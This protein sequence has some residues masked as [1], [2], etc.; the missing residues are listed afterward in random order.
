M[1]SPVRPSAA[2]SLS[3]RLLAAL[4]TALLTGT[5]RAGPPPTLAMSVLTSTATYLAAV[6]ATVALGGLIGIYPLPAGGA[7]WRDVLLL[8]G[9][10]GAAVGAYWRLV[11]RTKPGPARAWRAGAAEMAFLATVIAARDLPRLG[12]VTTLAGAAFTAL[13]VGGGLGW[14]VH[15]LVPHDGKPEFLPS[16]GD[17][18][19]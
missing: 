2:P 15:R 14:L 3:R 17:P 13:L 8:A 4:P 16:P 5:T 10:A 19:P 7:G 1:E 9:N 12:V 18:E 6:P 11:R